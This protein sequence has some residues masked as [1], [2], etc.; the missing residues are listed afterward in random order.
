[1]N[2]KRIDHLRPT[3]LKAIAWGNALRK[4]TILLIGLLSINVVAQNNT[5]SLN[6]YLKM[7]AMNNPGVKADFLAYKAS[8]QK[9]PQMGAYEDPQLE[10]G[11]FLE[12]MTIVD[13]RQVAEFKLMQMFP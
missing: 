9:I 6:S 4:I 12:P 8:L 7:A 3:A 10:M 13:G 11:L 5:D 2:N 1:M